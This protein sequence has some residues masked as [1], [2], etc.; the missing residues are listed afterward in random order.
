MKSICVYLG[1]NFGSNDTFRQATIKL[2]YEIAAR[3]YVLVYGGSSLGLMGLLASTVKTQGGTVIG[4]ITEYL[5]DKEIPLD[6]LDKLYVVNS[7]QERKK[8]MQQLSDVFLVMPGGLGTLEEAIETWNA[9]KIGEINKNIGFL[10]I[11]GFFNKLFSFTEHCKNSGFLDI[12]HSTMPVVHSEPHEL[13]R[14]LQ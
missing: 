3:E 2:A 12:K 13:L 8:L 9:I 5:L 1:A 6:N 7:M 11:D 14:A 10:N 4:V